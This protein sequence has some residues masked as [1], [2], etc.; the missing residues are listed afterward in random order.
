MKCSAKENSDLFYGALGGLGQFG[1]I[2][3]ARIALEPAPKMVN[4]KKKKMLKRKEKYRNKNITT[5]KVYLFSYISRGIFLN[6]NIKHFLFRYFF[7][8]EMD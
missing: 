4:C 7:I 2:T 5:Y 3:R 1:I 8:G 6:H